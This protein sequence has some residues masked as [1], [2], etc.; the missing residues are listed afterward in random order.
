VPQLTLV[1]F[2]SMSWQKPVLTPTKI[3]IFSFYCKPS[4]SSTTSNGCV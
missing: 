2:A 1:Q 4:V 3:S